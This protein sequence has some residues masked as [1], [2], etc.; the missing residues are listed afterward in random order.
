MKKYYSQAIYVKNNDKT[1]KKI[2]VHIGDNIVL[3][4]LILQYS[5]EDIRKLRQVAHNYLFPP[6]PLRTGV[7]GGAGKTP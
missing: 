1:S 6:R 2:L 4:F 7:T 3:L 5:T